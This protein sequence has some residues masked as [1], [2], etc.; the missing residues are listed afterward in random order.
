MCPPS[1]LHQ[2][3]KMPEEEEEEGYRMVERASKLKNVQ[4]MSQ[5]FLQLVIQIYLF[6]MLALMGGATMIAGVDAATFFTRICKQSQK[7]L[8]KGPFLT[9]ILFS[10]VATGITILVS[11]L[12]LVESAWT[13]HYYDLK[14]VAGEGDAWTTSS[15]V[16]A[17]LTFIMWFLLTT[18]VSVFS[19]VSIFVLAWMEVRYTQQTAPTY[20]A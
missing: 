19:L 3:K 2:I 20:L 14:R 18:F 5:S 4:A 15:K 11:I 7:V 13:N 1:E 17:F 8:F 9:L 6:V 16:K 10:D 12:N